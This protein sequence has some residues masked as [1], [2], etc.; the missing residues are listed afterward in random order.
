MI[1]FIWFG[2]LV[3]AILGFCHFLQTLVSR[4]GKPGTSAIGTLWQALWN[5][6][7]WTLFGAYV[8]FFWL[9]GL[10]LYFVFGRSARKAHTQ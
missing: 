5:W 2:T 10:A 3:G 6:A 8:F 4:L 1:D 7:L 9:I